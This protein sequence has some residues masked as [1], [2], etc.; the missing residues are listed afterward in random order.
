MCEPSFLVGIY[1]ALPD[2]HR[3]S[4]RGGRV[5]Y[6]VA[7]NGFHLVVICICL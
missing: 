4:T 1:P 2:D 5:C 7:C 6:F 3:S